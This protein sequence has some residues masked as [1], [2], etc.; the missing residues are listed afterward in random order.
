VVGISPKIFCKVIQLNTVF[1]MLKPLQS[2][3]RRLRHIWHRLLVT[4]T[5]AHFINDFKKNDR[6]VAPEIFRGKNHS[7]VKDYMA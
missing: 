6:Q 4:M 3:G 2:T 7:F 5:Q 1:E